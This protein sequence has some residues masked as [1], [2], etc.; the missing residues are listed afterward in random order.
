M[1]KNENPRDPVPKAK[2]GRPRK[3][4]VRPVAEPTQLERQLTLS[5]E[6]MQAELPKACDVSTKL[7]SKGYKKAGRA[8]NYI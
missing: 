3:G 8:I 2:R 7:N 4:E 6:E 1:I 5:L